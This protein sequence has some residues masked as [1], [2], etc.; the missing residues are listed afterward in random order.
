MKKN[1]LVTGGAGFLGS[2]LC[3]RLLN[4]GPNMHPNEGRV[5][6]NFI[7]QA[8][9]GENITIYGNGSQTRS[10]CY[11][12]DMIEGFILIMASK[13]DFFGPVN[14]GNPEEFSM[15]ELANHVI[16][17]TNSKSKIV[18]HQL[19]LDDPKQRQPDFSLAKKELNWQPKISLEVGLKK[20][21][22]YFDNLLKL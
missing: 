18:F 7:V 10:F 22:S 17:L 9:K 13:Q 8:L 19:P 1:F 14:L 15:L 3:N 2:H 11:V 16:G 21:F 12:D 5:V 4:D 20:T 6:S